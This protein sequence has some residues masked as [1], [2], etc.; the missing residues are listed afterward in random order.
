MFEFTCLIS[1][2]QRCFTLHINDSKAWEEAQ[3]YCTRLEG[4]DGKKGRLAVDDRPETHEILNRLLTTRGQ[5]VWLGGKTEPF[6]WNWAPPKT[7]QQYFRIMDRFNLS[8]QH[9]SLVTL[10]IFY[11]VLFNTPIF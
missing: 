2:T 10:N 4:D 3:E 9:D 8:H 1:G 11:D 5:R 7:G 6:Y